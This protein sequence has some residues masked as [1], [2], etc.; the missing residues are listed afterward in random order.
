MSTF[1]LAIIGAG[2]AGA[3]LAWRLAGRT[4]LVVLERESQAGVH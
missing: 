4:R 3:S 1:D 2:I